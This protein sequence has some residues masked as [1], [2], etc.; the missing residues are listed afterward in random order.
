MTRNFKFFYHPFQC[1]A[2][3]S[4]FS[5]ENLMVMKSKNPSNS[6]A[7]RTLW[8]TP[9]MRNW[10]NKIFHLPPSWHYQISWENSVVQVNRQN[11]EAIWFHILLLS[12]LLKQCHS[13]PNPIRNYCRIELQPHKTSH[14][15]GKNFLIKFF[16][17]IY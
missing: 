7:L 6:Q 4:I 14:K 11:Q 12:T 10:N 3:W 1:D 17:S 8:I 15:I 9:K 2:N 5:I 13:S 16:D